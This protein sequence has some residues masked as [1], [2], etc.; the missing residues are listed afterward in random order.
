MTEGS[1]ND[2]SS[3][4]FPDLTSLFVIPRFNLLIVIPRFNRGIHRLLFEIPVPVF[5]GT[6]PRFRG[7]KLDRGI[8]S[9]FQGD[10]HRFPSPFSRGQAFAGMTERN[11][12]DKKEWSGTFFVIPRLDRGIYRFP[13]TW[14]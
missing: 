6:G 1:G 8:S 9:R 2:I 5:T 10:I 13:L 12:N 4:S 7:D 14:E 3:L 11:G